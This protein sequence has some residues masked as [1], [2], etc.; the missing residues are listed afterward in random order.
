MK[1]KTNP[2]DTINAALLES[3]R[4]NFKTKKAINEI[5]IIT[6]KG[7]M[8]SAGTNSCIFSENRKIIGKIVRNKI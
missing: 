4:I 7:I 8:I 6:N 3:L 5:G 1:N 2:T